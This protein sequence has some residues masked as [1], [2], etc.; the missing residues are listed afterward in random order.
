LRVKNLKKV[1]I[2]GLLYSPKFAFDVFTGMVRDVFG[3]NIRRSYTMEAFSKSFSEGKR[4]ESYTWGLAKSNKDVE[5]LKAYYTSPLAV[6]AYTYG[7]FNVGSK[8]IGGGVRKINTL[9]KSG[10]LDRAIRYIPKTLR[11]YPSKYADVRLAKGM[12]YKFNRLGSPTFLK[13]RGELLY[14][15]R[16]I[17]RFAS[18]TASKW[19]SYGTS[20][21]YYTSSLTG[22]IKKVGMYPY[23]HFAKRPR[24]VET[25]R[26]YVAV[27]DNVSYIS[28]GYMKSFFKPKSRVEKA[29]FKP[30][31]TFD[32]GKVKRFYISDKMVAAELKGTTLKFKPSIV[33]RPV[34]DTRDFSRVAQLL[35]KGTSKQHSLYQSPLKRFDYTN[36]FGKSIRYYEESYY[37]SKQWMNMSPVF[38]Y[39]PKIGISN[40][41]IIG[42]KIQLDSKKIFDRLSKPDVRLSMLQR[43]GLDISSITTP[44][45]GTVSLN[46][47]RQLQSQRVDT[48]Y[49]PQLKMK[50]ITKTDI[51]EP[52]YPM[53]KIPTPPSI[54]TTSTPFTIPSFLFED[55]YTKRML[56][57]MSMDNLFGKGWRKRSWLN[58][59]DVI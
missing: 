11:D 49:K 43:T 45:M 58:N 54:K 33:V 16:V 10:K 19:G 37:I 15:G 50:Q 7:V 13:G 2:G 59:K 18:K 39:K 47:M 14:G 20:W 57:N 41:S 40:V 8:L 44:A 55:D 38:K 31:R 32:L 35:S 56:K 17:D 1:A 52:S 34:V 26:S 6:T 4:W 23:E 21:K 5:L 36:V 28:R 12:S 48:K 42:S 46:M 3:R 30:S 53:F 51:D 25:G 29:F 9:V 22:E 27:G 24:W